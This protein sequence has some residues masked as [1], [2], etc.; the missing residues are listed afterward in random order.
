MARYDV[1]NGDADG[2]CA[3]QQLRLAEP[4]DAQLVTGPKRDVALLARV[5]AGAGDLVTVLDVAMAANGPALRTLLERGAEVIYFDHHACGEVP[6]HPRLHVHL[7]PGPA[8]CTSLLVDRWLAGAHRRW[9]LV[10][11][12]GDGLVDEANSLASVF[13]LD[14]AQRQALHDLGTDLNYNAYGE[15]ESDLIAAPTRLHALLRGHLD[16][17]ALD[18]DGTLARIRATRVADFA[19]ACEHPA[20]PVGAHAIACV[21]PD[22]PWSRRVRGVLAHDLVRRTPDRG[23]AVLSPDGRGAYVVS[24]RAPLTN[25]SGADVL[26][27]RF[28]SGEGRAGAAGIDR[29]PAV[30]LDAFLSALARAFAPG[31][32]GH[33]P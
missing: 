14:T 16:P 13:G 30:Q 7:D 32:P 24:V 2:L 4:V 29:L 15:H 26:C 22:A 5:P 27:R 23:V 19:L 20:I 9:A 3:L 25:R 6:V 33:R 31:G 11:A 17:L 1:F 28:P 10:G 18:D 12:Y 21:L 8:V